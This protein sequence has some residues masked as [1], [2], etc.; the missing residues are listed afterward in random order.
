MAARY[1]GEEFAVILPN[2]PMSHRRPADQMGVRRER[3]RAGL[4]AAGART[5]RRRGINGGAEEVGE[6]IR[7][8]IAA[9]ASAARRAIRPSVI[10]V[11]VGRRRLPAQDGSAEDLVSNADA[12]LYKAKRG[13]KNRV[14]TYG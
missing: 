3:R 5:C 12:A 14:E 11:S 9:C 1:G 2:T 7:R 6:R 4:A 8:R 13:G 10:T